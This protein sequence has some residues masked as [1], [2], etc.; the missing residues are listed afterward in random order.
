[1]NRCGGDQFWMSVIFG[2][3]KASSVFHQTYPAWKCIRLEKTSCR[4]K[5]ALGVGKS[6][7]ESNCVL[8]FKGLPLALELRRPFSYGP[9]GTG[10]HAHPYMADQYLAVSV[11]WVWLL[12]ACRLPRH[13][14]PRHATPRHATPRHDAIASQINSGRRYWLRATS[15]SSRIHARSEAVDRSPATFR[16]VRSFSVGSAA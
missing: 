16:A 8:A 5:L 6:T 3:D 2:P 1:M 13:A 9:T 4:L 14:T 11:V 12:S 7:Q 10:V 15:C